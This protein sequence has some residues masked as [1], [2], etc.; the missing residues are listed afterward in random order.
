MIETINCQLTKSGDYSE[1]DTP[2]PIPNTEVKPFN[3]DGTWAETPWESRK[4]PDYIKKLYFVGRSRAFYY[5]VMQ[6]AGA[7][8]GCPLVFLLSCYFL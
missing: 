2:V 3:A 8:F 4:L 6:Y 5:C 7:T 1:R